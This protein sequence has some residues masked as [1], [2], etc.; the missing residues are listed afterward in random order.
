MT[1]DLTL[2]YKIF[3]FD[4]IN[5]QPLF[6]V[7]SFRN[8]ADLIRDSLSKLRYYLVFILYKL[9]LI[10]SDYLGIFLGH[11]SK[12]DFLSGLNAFPAMHEFLQKLELLGLGWI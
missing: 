10:E 7:F 4:H 6:L 8:R 12:L 9:V 3:H 1:F 2:Y 11:L 5:I